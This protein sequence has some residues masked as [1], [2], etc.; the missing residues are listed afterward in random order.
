MYRHLKFR[1]SEK[2]WKLNSQIT[3]DYLNLSGSITLTRVKLQQNIYTK[4]VIIQFRVINNSYYGASP[5]NFV[6]HFP[7]VNL[8]IPRRISVRT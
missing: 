2:N 5:L 4:L 8:N 7:G 1:L 3:I 6:P